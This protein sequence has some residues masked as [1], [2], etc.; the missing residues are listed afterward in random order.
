[1]PSSFFVP[2]GTLPTTAPSYVERH[3][4][5]EL[6]AALAA[7][8]YCFVLTTRQMG[9]SSLMVRTAIRLK[10]QG[11]R[12]AVLDLTAIGQN[13]TPEQ[14]YD[15]LL[16]S[17]GSQLGLEGALEACWTDRAAERLGPMQRFFAAIS[18]VILPS[19]QPASPPSEDQTDRTNRT[20]RTD[21]SD[22]APSPTHPL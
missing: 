1:M 3:A 19:L 12:V 22:A 13:L 15:G 14:W 2:G 7:G 17:L 10:A 9:K 5:G 6:I 20:N 4:D 21:R 11:V 16:T 8:E 18:Q